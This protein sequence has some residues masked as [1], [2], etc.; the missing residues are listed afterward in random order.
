[1]RIPFL[2]KDLLNPS[3]TIGTDATITIQDVNEP[4]TGLQVDPVPVPENTPGAVAGQVNVEDPE[5]D[6]HFQFQL[7]DSRFIVSAGQL[8]LKPNGASFGSR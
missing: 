2:S 7:S 6:Q 1:M 3:I 4:P 8:R 5:G